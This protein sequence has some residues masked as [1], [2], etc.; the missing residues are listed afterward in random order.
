MLLKLSDRLAQVALTACRIGSWL[1]VPLILIIMFDVITRKWVFA[2]Q[3]VANS[4]LGT[5]L[6]AT[7]LQEMEWHIHAVIF[8]LA[9]GAALIR[10]THVRVDI[11]REKRSTRAQGWVELFGLLVFALPF[12]S[13]MVW[14]SWQF[15]VKAYVSGEGSAALTGIPQRWIVKSFMIAGF[16]LLWLALVSTLLRVLVFLFGKPAAQARAAERLPQIN[17][18]LIDLASG[19]PVR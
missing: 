11:W 3:T 14:L 4:P 2:Q 7:R 6:S 10:N 13:L 9:F 8:L 19:R 18:P 15:V 12:V 1:I 16:G 17:A 5:L